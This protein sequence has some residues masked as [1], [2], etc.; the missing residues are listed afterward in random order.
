[1]SMTT[2][3]VVFVT[4][5]LVAA[6]SCSSNSAPGFAATSPSPLTTPFVG[7]WNGS[8]NLVSTGSVSLQ[9][10]MGASGPD[11]MGAWAMTFANGS[12]AK[13]GDLTGGV[14]VDGSSM[15]VALHSSDSECPATVS[16]VINGTGT[17]ITGSYT[18]TT[19]TCGQPIGGPVVLSKR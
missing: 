16:G 4:L 17:Q 15:S 6:I 9:L 5:S 3:R 12:P 7:T 11:L 18:S 13:N 2:F 14:N 1:M 10:T 19:S 8:M